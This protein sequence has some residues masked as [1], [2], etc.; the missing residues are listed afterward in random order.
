MGWQGTETTM[1][2]GM[3][4]AKMYCCKCGLKLNRQKIS[5]VLVKGEDDYS[6]T[7]L[8]KKMLVPGGFVSRGTIG[9]DEIKKFTYVY[10]CEHCNYLITYDE[11]L[12]ISNAQNQHNKKVLLDNEFNALNISLVVDDSVIS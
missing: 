2:L 1:P 11:Q 5:K 4:F 9:M 12:I 3:L 7:F 6:S 10:K 8:H